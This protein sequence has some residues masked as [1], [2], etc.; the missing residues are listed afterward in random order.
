MVNIN[1]GNEYL[2][3]VFNCFNKKDFAINALRATS[4]ILS[5]KQSGILKEVYFLSFHSEW[6]KGKHV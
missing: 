2:K 1:W 3:S 6:W 5:F 4:I